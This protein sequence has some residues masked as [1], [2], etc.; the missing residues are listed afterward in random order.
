MLDLQACEESQSKHTEHPPSTHP[1]LT[2]TMSLPRS[3]VSHAVPSSPH[4]QHFCAIFLHWLTS[5]L[6]LHSNS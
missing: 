4:F 3:P 6:A 2:Y 1:H 5:P